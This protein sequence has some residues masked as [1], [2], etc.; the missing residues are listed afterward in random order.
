MRVHK[1]DMIEVDDT[2]GLRRIKT[3]H[4]LSP[5]NNILYLAAHNEGGELQKRHDDKDDLF[6]WDFANIGG[7]KKRNAAQGPH[8]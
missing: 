4:R 6:R 2:D 8:R 1:G 5:S 7:L 3:V